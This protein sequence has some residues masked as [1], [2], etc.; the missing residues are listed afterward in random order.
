M[1]RGSI[2]GCRGVVSIFLNPG[3]ACVRCRERERDKCGDEMLDQCD[4]CAVRV[5]DVRHLIGE[6]LTNLRGGRAARCA[7]GAPSGGRW[8]RPMT[9]TLMGDGDGK[10]TRHP[11]GRQRNTSE[12]EHTST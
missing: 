8:R 3:L 7:A 10:V 11:S 4:P 6:H 5:R 1:G 9:A 2:F 12:Q